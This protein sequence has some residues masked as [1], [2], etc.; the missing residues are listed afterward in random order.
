MIKTTNNNI[1][2]GKKMK[3]KLTTDLK[4][5]HFS[6]FDKLPSLNSSPYK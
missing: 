1:S 4:C 2:R 3:G 6:L 5:L